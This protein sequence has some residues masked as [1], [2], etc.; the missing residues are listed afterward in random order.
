[1]NLSL[2]PD[3]E[4]FVNQKVESGKYPTADDVIHEGLRLLQERDEADRK[5]ED[6]RREIAVGI[7]QIEQGKVAPLSAR[8]MLVRLR[9]AKQAEVEMRTDD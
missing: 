8:E 7:V 3:L 1:M 5:R 2:P 9:Q 6:L 4:Q